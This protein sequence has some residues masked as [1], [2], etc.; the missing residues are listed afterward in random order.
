VPSIGLAA[1]S[2]DT[3]HYLS[4]TGANYGPAVSACADDVV[5]TIN[6]QPC[7]NVTMATVGAECLGLTCLGTPYVCAVP[8]P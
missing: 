3:H 8:A 6:G 5:V 2:D 7:D 4:L 1:A